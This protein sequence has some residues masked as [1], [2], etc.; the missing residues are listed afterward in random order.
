LL[1]Q[2]LDPLDSLVEITCGFRGLTDS[3]SCLVLGE[4]ALG[5]LPGHFCRHLAGVREHIVFVE[6]KKAVP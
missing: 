6:S 3:E 4:L 1:L 5:M 2:P